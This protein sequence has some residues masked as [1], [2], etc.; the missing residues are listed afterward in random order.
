MRSKPAAKSRCGDK[1]SLGLGVEAGRRRIAWPR[2][3]EHRRYL[4]TTNSTRTLDQ[5]AGGRTQ[6]DKDAGHEKE[7]DH[8]P[9]HD[10]QHFR[11]L[12]YALKPPR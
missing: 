3:F 5:D 7:T 2:G 12:A 6:H 9:D 4:R 10:L 1:H 8:N 11:V